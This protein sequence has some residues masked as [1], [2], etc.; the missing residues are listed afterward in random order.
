M[1]PADDLLRQALVLKTL[2]A[3]ADEAELFAHADELLLFLNRLRDRLSHSPG[4]RIP[5]SSLND[6][7]QRLESNPTLALQDKGTREHLRKLFMKL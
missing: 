4:A 2:L 1:P 7:I 5:A 6:I 3:S